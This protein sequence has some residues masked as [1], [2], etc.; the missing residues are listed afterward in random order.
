M[1][2]TSTDVVQGSESG[3]EG[4]GPSLGERISAFYREVR[5]QRR[6]LSRA[7]NLIKPIAGEEP[8]AADYADWLEAH[9]GLDGLTL[10][11]AELDA[12]REELV[13]RMERTVKKLRMKAR[14]RFVR[15]L[16]EAAGDEE[17]VL[18]KVSEAPLV[19]Y[20]DPLTFEVDFSTG[21]ARLL[22]GREPIEELPLEPQAL[23]EARAAAVE[24]L[25]AEAVEPAEFFDMLRA[26]YRMV[27]AADGAEPGDRVDLVD[28]LVPLSMLRVERT[29]WRRDGAGALD[30]YPR[31]RL[32]YQLARLRGAGLL[33]RDGVRLD[34]GAATGG[35]TRDKRDVLYVPTG[36]TSGQYYGSLRFV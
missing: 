24:D 3:A 26:A 18:E 22:Y 33:E 21:E 14:L 15:D 23:V 4:K 29:Q 8:D 31:Y 25:K 6:R 19:M 5:R 30:D 36:A 1:T 28:V 34:L 35:S 27:A 11:E 12:A 9:D 16:E 20:A 17:L 32:A 13:A 2:D 10:P 7:R